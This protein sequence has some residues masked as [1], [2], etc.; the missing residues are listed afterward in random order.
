M[1][2]HG[3]GGLLCSYDLN[4]SLGVFLNTA[5]GFTITL[6]VSSYALLLGHMADN[7]GLV[8]RMFPLLLRGVPE[9]L[10]VEINKFVLASNCPILGLV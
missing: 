2:V 4:F 7:D 1:K 8:K 3:D 10:E 9:L 6:D 5:T